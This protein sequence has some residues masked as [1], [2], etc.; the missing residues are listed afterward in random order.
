MAARF[1][2]RTSWDTSESS[3]A[4]AIRERR[5]A[6]LPLL[7]LTVSNPTLCGFD[8]DSQAILAA[9]QAHAAMTYDPDPL[10][11]RSAR[12]AVTEYYSEHQAVVDPDEVIL[13]T[14]TSEAYSFLFRLLCDAG[15]E[16]LVA[17]PSY[18]LF[19]FI[20]DLNDVRLR[21]YL[22]FEDFGWWIDFADL[23]VRITTRTRAIVLVHPNNPTGHAT[24]QAE[25][26]L[27]QELC[28]SRG[29]ALIVDEVF[30]DYG[31]DSPIKSCAA[32]SHLCLTFVVSGI[33]KICALPQ[34][35]VGWISCFGPD[36]LRREALARLAV[37]AD[38]FLSM[39]SPA[40]HALKV[41]LSGREAIQQQ[42]RLRVRENIDIWQQGNCKLQHVEAGW[43]GMLRMPQHLGA[44][45][46]A[47]RLVT[48][49]GILVHPGTFYGFP[50]AHV[51]V[52][53]L[54]LP[55]SHVRVATKE[56]NEWCESN[57]L[58]ES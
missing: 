57:E 31:L 32:D 50:R 38:T 24:S 21:N 26:V 34:M 23:E 15:D 10:G 4:I 58:L 47:E 54:L 6:S 20:A 45:D 22:L 3:L 48:Q 8:Y 43:S 56:L 9:L 12:E 40:Q 46:L 5:A 19:E 53:S 39:N 7:D 13:T 30:L 36:S 41:W 14:S 2:K 11:I 25:R 33:S 18:P 17:R 27:L 44:P 28:A 49:A 1:S 29:L 37:V 35:K 55:H 42:I 51:I 52:I 16:V